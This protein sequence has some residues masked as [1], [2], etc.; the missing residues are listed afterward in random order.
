MVLW[1]IFF[2]VVIEMNES[3]KMNKEKILYIRQFEKG[4]KILSTDCFTGACIDQYH[5]KLVRKFKRWLIR[6]KKGDWV[7]N[8]ELSAD[9]MDNKRL[10]IVR[11]IFSW[12]PIYFLEYLHRKYPQAHIVYWLRNALFVEGYRSGITPDNIQKFLELQRKLGFR[13]ITFDKGDCRKYNLLYAPQV[14]P[15]KEL[16]RQ[17]KTTEK[18]RIKYDIFWYGKDKGRIPKVLEMKKV[19]DSQ[20]LTYWFKIVKAFGKKYTSN[21][22]WLL[23]DDGVSYAEYVKKMLE[24]RAVLEI[25]Q[26]GQNG[27]TARP[28]EAMR[29]RRKLITNY[30]GIREYDFYCKENVFILGIDDPHN[31]SDFIHSPYKELPQEI[32]N[33]YT[34]EGMIRHIYHN[35]NWDVKEL[36]E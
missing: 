30:K 22:N 23:I 18:V 5:V 6:H 35:M 25:M 4:Q 15:M 36:E 20:K 8:R 26:E 12:H 31:L 33:R 2:V 14:W 32:I 7:F 3:R 16:E 1:E 11:E 24:S 13:V 9:T 34:M 10:I 17:Q 21:L 27:L 19:C 29:L 28:I